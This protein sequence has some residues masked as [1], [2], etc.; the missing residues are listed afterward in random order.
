MGSKQ[1]RYALA[2]GEVRSFEAEVR[3]P[4]GVIE[5]GLFEPG[6]VIGIEVVEADRRPTLLG[7]PAAPVTRMGC[8]LVQSPRVWRQR[9]A[10]ICLAHAKP[11]P[12]RPRVTLQRRN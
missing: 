7:K 1:F 5:P 4:R 8:S 11:W 9:L 3:K 12:V 6:I 10:Q 2:I